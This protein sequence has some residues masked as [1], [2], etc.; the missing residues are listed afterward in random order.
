M[1]QRPRP[2]CSRWLRTALAI[3]ASIAVTGAAG[4]APVVHKVTIDGFEFRPPLVS[5][6]QGDIVEWRNSDP[7]P[8]TATARDAGLDSGAI[9]GGATYRF[10]ATRRGRFGYVCSL[11]PT[12]KGT[13]VV[14]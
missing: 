13:L 2:R 8:H 12:M 10:T 3:A 4:A 14:E 9:Q 1:A 5:V 7:L 6:K 11:H